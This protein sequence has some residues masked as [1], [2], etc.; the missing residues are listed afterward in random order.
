M[1][2]I[3]KNILACLGIWFLT[4]VVFAFLFMVRTS[5]PRL[6]V[7]RPAIDREKL[8]H[9]TGGRPERHELKEDGMNSS[10]SAHV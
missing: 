2:E 8:D 5:R 6:N 9:D 7:L 3:L 4:S 1:F 10:F